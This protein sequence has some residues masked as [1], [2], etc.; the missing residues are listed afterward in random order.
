ME[1]SQRYVFVF[2][3]FF[4]CCNLSWEE[5][6][7]VSRISANPIEEGSNSPNVMNRFHCFHLYIAQN[8][9]EVETVFYF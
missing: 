7:F 2:W 4:A 3:I 5:E 6:F 1:E 9:D 8:E